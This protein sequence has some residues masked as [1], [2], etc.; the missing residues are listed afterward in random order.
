MTLTEGD[1]IAELDSGTDRLRLAEEKAR[2]AGL[3]MQRDRILDEIRAAEGALGAADGQG[4]AAIGEA[5][6]RLAAARADESVHRAALV[7][8]EG[9]AATAVDSARAETDRRKALVQAAQKVVERLEWEARSVQKDRLAALAARGRDLAEVEAALRSGTESIARLELEIERRRIRAPIS[10]RVGELADLKPGSVVQAGRRLV[11]I[12]PEGDVR[13][14]AGFLPS[15]APGRIRPG[16]PARLRLDGYPWTRYGTLD[17]EVTHVGTEARNGLVR[18]ELSVRNGS[19]GRIPLE[20]GLSGVAEV[21]V[22][23]LSPAVLAL[24]LA[25][26]LF[27]GRRSDLPGSREETR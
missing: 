11:V 5:R 22:D 7:T 17:A 14:V 15:A 3:G 2:V 8:A 13:V 27:G 20:H 26:G 25:G 21:E 18:V 12:V 6:R 24:K 23:H 19:G 9:Q 4:Q 16:Q 1:G 10:G